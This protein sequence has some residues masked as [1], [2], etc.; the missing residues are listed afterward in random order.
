VLTAT[1]LVPVAIAFLLAT[2]VLVLARCTTMEEAYASIEWRVIILIACMSAFG[3]AM[4]QS[5]TA[6]FIADG[7]VA[8]VAP[9]GLHATL[10]VFAVLAV[11]L[12]QPMSN[13]A[14]ALVLIPVAVSTAGLLGLDPRTFAVMV[15]LSASLSFITPLEPASLLVFGVGKYQ[16]RDF[17]VVGLPL[18]LI[19]LAMLVFLVP[20]VWP[21]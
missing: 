8:S 7:I 10:A 3:V 14:A 12:T 9:L 15:T 11:V 21:P 2:I 1:G 6:E 20:I 13:A 17:A 4:Q 5:G 18:T 16:F 19:A